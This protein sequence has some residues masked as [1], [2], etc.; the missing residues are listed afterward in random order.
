MNQRQATVNTILSVLSEKG[1]NYELN[2]ETPV[3]EY[4]TADDKKKVVSVICQGFLSGH[5][6]MS[7]EGKSKYFGD[8]AELRKYT[9]GLVNNWIRKAT[10]FNNGHKYEIKN[11]GSRTGSSDEQLKALRELL[12]IT[13]D[14][15]VRGEIEQAIAE[16]MEEIKP[17]VEINASAL[18]AHLRH[19]VK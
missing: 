11:K 13:T 3:S 15:E 6:E 2:G 7:D 8:Q 9:V 16:R 5:I 12:K 17:K 4:L 19:L 18:P 1:V 10:E 14:S